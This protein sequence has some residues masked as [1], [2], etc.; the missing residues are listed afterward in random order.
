MD[1]SLKVECLETELSNAL[2][3]IEQQKGQ[4]KVVRDENDLAKIAEQEESIKNL[5]TDLEYVKKELIEAR[6]HKSASDDKLSTVQ[7]K[8]ET[9]QNNINSLSDE[10]KVFF[11]FW[12][13]VN[14]VIEDWKNHE[15]SDFYL[16]KTDKNS[17]TRQFRKFKN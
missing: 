8:I 6:A 14:S 1:V 3:V 4:V 10:G 12:Y 17:N 2:Q 13:T 9:M 5:Q 16:V 15:N 7:D 11:F